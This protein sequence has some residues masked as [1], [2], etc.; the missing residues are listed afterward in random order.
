MERRVSV[1]RWVTMDNQ[2][3]E[4]HMQGTGDNCIPECQS[5]STFLLLLGHERGSHSV[6]HMDH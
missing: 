4:R 3:H 5:S 2:K 1:N 6:P